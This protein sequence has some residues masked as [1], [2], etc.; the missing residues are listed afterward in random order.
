MKACKH[1]EGDFVNGFWLCAKCYKKLADRPRRLIKDMMV[2][3]IG[4]RQGVIHAP[5]AKVDG[6]TLSHFVEFMALRL[7]AL[8][9]G[10]FVKGDAVSYAMDI[11]G[12]F[13]EPFGHK[14]FS[15]DQEGA[16][17]IIKED[18]QYWDYDGGGPNQ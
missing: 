8:T 5:I 10:S 14:D 1:W 3:D 9:R 12:S 6:V 2:E 17:E 18:L 7:I 13:G 16:W 4:F 15:W 11:L